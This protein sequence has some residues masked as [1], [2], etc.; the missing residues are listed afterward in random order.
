MTVVLTLTRFAAGDP[1][2]FLLLSSYK[3]CRSVLLLVASRDPWPTMLT[4]R[5]LE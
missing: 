5:G 2:I 4:G 3:L 1:S